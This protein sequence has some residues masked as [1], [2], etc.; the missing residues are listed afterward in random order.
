[1]EVQ[2]P[3]RKNNIQFPS[4]ES[5]FDDVRLL[6]PNSTIGQSV[7]TCMLALCINNII[8]IIFYRRK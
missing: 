5:D 7:S 4:S 8:I 3:S 2:L 1:M 6:I